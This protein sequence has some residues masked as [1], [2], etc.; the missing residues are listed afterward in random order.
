MQSKSH[1]AVILLLSCLLGKGAGNEVYLLFKHTEF[2]RI[3]HDT[4]LAE[5]S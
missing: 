1:G 2:S 4:T 5:G 3:F